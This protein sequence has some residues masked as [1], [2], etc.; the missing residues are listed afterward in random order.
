MRWV[1]SS[2]TRGCVCAPDHHVLHSGLFG[3]V[4]E[5]L[6]VLE[7]LHRVRGDVEHARHSPQGGSTGRRLVVVDLD[8]LH[9]HVHRRGTRSAAN[10]ERMRRDGSSSVSWRWRTSVT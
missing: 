4:N 10:E 6:A 9:L 1:N 7:H 3:C 5:Q 2:V 8:R